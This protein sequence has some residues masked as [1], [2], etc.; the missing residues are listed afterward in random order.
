MPSRGSGPYTWLSAISS[1][2]W[3]TEEYSASVAAFRAIFASRSP[4]GDRRRISVHQRST[5][6]SSSSG[7]TTALTRPMPRAS[8]ALY[9]RV[10]KRTSRA[11]F[12]PTTAGM[13]WQ[14]HQQGRVP[15]FGP[16]WPKRP[17]VSLI[18]RS[19]TMFS[20]LPPPMQ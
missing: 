18:V 6:A 15:I 13:S 5:S 14:P 12:S 4:S 8:C 3:L 19:L 1:I 10:R 7:S 9:W 16:A 11:R 20:S 2:P 17:V